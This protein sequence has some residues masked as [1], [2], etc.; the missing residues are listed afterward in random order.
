MGAGASLS[1]PDQHPGLSLFSNRPPAQWAGGLVVSSHGQRK[2]KTRRQGGPVRGPVPGH[3][4]PCPLG[5]RASPPAR[6]CAAGVASRVRSSRLLHRAGAPGDGRSVGTPSRPRRTI[7]RRAS[8]RS[9]WVKRQPLG[10]V[11]APPN[12]RTALPDR[13]AGTGG[14][15]SLGGVLPTSCAVR[16][17]QAAIR[18][19]DAAPLGQT[20]HETT[21]DSASAP[22]PHPAPG[23][24]RQRRAV[25]H[26]AALG[27]GAE[28]NRARAGTCTGRPSARGLLCRSGRLHR[29]PPYNRRYAQ[30]LRNCPLSPHNSAVIRNRPHRAGTAQGDEIRRLRAGRSRPACGRACDTAGPSASRRAE[31]LAGHRLAALSL[32]GF[33][34]RRSCGARPLRWPVSASLSGSRRCRHSIAPASSAPATLGPLV[35]RVGCGLR[36]LR[37]QAGHVAGPP[38]PIAT[39]GGPLAAPAP[40]HP[41]QRRGEL[42]PAACGVV[43]QITPPTRGWTKQNPPGDRAGGSAEHINDGPQEQAGEE[44]R[45]GLQYQERRAISA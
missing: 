4:P 39:Q 25:G 32:P 40:A 14:G 38:R 18:A 37:P 44:T 23:N 33:P 5:L 43:A 1:L 20:A 2:R 31:L 8:P 10:G 22:A 12:A 15:Y 27:T 16:A 35:G 45:N 21:G 29:P 34:C 30:L 36:H 3:G 7:P 42:A 17:G 6:P 9:S 26:V 28:S 13:Q 11:R 41:S 19:E 24:D